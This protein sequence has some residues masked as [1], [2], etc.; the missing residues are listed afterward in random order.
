MLGTSFP[1]PGGVDPSLIAQA[2]NA[3]ITDRGLDR[4]TELLL[5]ED[6]RRTDG[7]VYWKKLAEQV[8]RASPDGDQLWTDVER[9]TANLEV[10]ARARADAA[11]RHVRRLFGWLPSVIV[12]VVE[13]FEHTPIAYTHGHTVLA[14]EFEAYLIDP[15]PLGERR[16]PLRPALAYAT[17]DQAARALVANLD[18]LI[19]GED[20]VR[21]IQHA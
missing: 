11:K 2:I 17:A 20:L 7:T 15:D 18:Q 5:D 1:R 16:H 8:F 3:A 19:T 4:L 21:S 9:V 6:N 14:S 10:P 12:D 13:S